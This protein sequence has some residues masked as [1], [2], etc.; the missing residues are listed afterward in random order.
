MQDLQNLIPK[1]MNQNEIEKKVLSLEGRIEALEKRFSI[2]PEETFKVTDAKKL[3]IKEFLISKNV[4]DDVKRT[5]VI[6]YYL[7]HIEK[8]ESINTDDL[9]KGFSLAKHSL[10]GNIND[11]V[12][13]NIKNGH[14]MEA[15]EEKDS[16]KAWVLTSTGEKC[17][18]EE[19]S[20]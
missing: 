11:K 7:E 3:S 2:R 17:V 1:T 10:P 16:K 6:A 12:N 4:D 18:E 14:M 8:N 20:K 19:L 5:L 9:K 15:E 13:M